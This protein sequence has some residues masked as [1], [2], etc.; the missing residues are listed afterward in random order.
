MENQTVKTNDVNQIIKTV[1]ILS[2]IL[3]SLFFGLYK[4]FRISGTFETPLYFWS[5]LVFSIIGLI[6]ILLSILFFKSI[7][8]LISNFKKNKMRKQKDYLNNE[9]KQVS[10]P[11]MKEDIR[12]K[13]EQAQQEKSI[14]I[15]EKLKIAIEYTKKEFALY[16][17][18]ENLIVLCE[19]I[20]IYAE[21]GNLENIKSI[22]VQELTVKDLRHFGWNIWN[23]FET[24]RNQKEIGL[25]LKGAFS[26][27]L[28]NVKINSLTGN[29]TV[30]ENEGLIKIIRCLKTYN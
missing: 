25:F 10:L 17:S 30:D 12:I 21:K 24:K 28:E 3:A 2:I 6:I 1:T 14:E 4:S 23:H 26:K 13:R 9:S 16:T 22:S 19:N 5:V 29:L 8:E 20:K 15:Q 18:I 7:S 11:E 27:A